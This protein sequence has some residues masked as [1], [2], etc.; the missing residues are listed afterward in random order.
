M[1]FSKDGKYFGFTQTDINGNFRIDSGLGTGDYFVIASKGSAYTMQPAQVHVIAGQETKNVVIKIKGD[2]IVQA[3]VEG[4][5]TDDQGRPLAGAEVSGGGNTTVTDANGN[6]VLIVS[7]IG[8]TSSEVEIT[9]SKRGYKDQTKKVN[10]SAGGTYTLDFQLEALPSGT[11]K[12]RV[13]GISAAKKK[14]QLSLTLSSTNVSVGSTVIISGQLSPA[15]PG[16]VTL[17]YSFNGSDFTE[18]ASIALSD[19]SYSYQF[20]PT[21]NGIYEFKAIW[22]GDNEYEQAVSEVKTLIV[23]KAAE[24]VTPKVSIS[25]S[26]TS[27]K[28]GDSI[29]V[30][31]SIK[32]FKGSTKVI[33]VITSPSGSTNQYEVTSTNGKFSYTF[34]VDVKGKWKVKALVPASEI[35]NNASSSEVTVDVSEKKKCIIATVTFGSEVSPE[36]NFLRGFRDNLIL[37]TFSGRRFYV[38]FD[39]FYYSWSTPVAMYIEEHPYLKGIVKVILYPLLGILK[40]T[41]VA[42]MPWFNM[43]PE[44]ATI[45]AGFIASTLI[46][47]VYV[48]PIALFIH[49]IRARYGKAKPVPEKLVKANG[50]LS[51]FS[52]IA[53]SIGVLLL[54]PWLSTFSSSLFVLSN[55]SLASIAA[56]Y[57]LE[58]K[59]IIK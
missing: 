37:K 31:G 26:K 20:K 18:L 34:K 15:R 32:P 5:V 47:L 50:Y 22:P 10:V 52:L 35:Y 1:A 48:F 38:A 44:V 49:L 14:A 3:V 56:L 25:L 24:K 23:V 33:I 42:V 57:I 59:K 28:V 30:S 55:I 13:L 7:I 58:R 41:A 53:L 27:A 12:G 4:K 45:T 29:T 54:N 8:K 46:G 40:I 6:Y 51:L 43:A 39:A 17:Y 2:V 11:L 36:V 19:G 9:A 16:E 21:E